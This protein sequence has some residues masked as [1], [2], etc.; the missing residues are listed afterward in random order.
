[1]DKLNEST[2][3]QYI[4]KLHVRGESASVVKRKMASVEK[5]I[6]WAKEKGYIKE[7]EYKE[8]VKALGKP[9]N[10]ILNLLAS[11]RSGFQDLIERCRNKFGMTKKPIQPTT[12]HQPPTTTFGLQHYIGLI[13]ILIFMAALGAGIYNQFF[14]K[15]EKSLAYSATPVRAGRILSFQGRLTDSL[16]NPIITATNAT[17][18]LY[19]VSTG[20]TALY[21]A[22]PCS[23]T[24][25]E[26]GIFN[27]L[28]GGSGYTPTSPQ[29]VC[30]T[31]ITSDI[32]SENPN[33]Y[34]GVT[35]ALDAEM[36][37]RQQIAN[38]GYAINS[39]TL[40]GL[41]PGT[42]TSNIP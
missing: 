26:D 32:F 33:V 41:P 35:I 11:L 13:I 6:G 29:S 42:G 19:N 9:N 30:G 18:K 37:P 2:I 39:E 40:Q 1:M 38:V 21:T 15:S 28:V 14:L 36:T 25:D 10:V 17:F 20:G 7:N 3:K 12:N 22:G 5:F 24:P 16:G 31:E 4:S 34:M 27:T 8:M 23:T